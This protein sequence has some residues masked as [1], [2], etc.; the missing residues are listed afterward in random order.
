MNKQAINKQLSTAKL[1]WAELHGKLDIFATDQQ[2]AETLAQ[3][4]R[5]ERKIEALERTLEVREEAA[6]MRRKYSA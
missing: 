3:I 5:Y 2:N 1:I 6:A 4:K